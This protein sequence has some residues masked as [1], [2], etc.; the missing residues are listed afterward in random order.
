MRITRLSAIAVALTA[1]AM[2]AGTSAASAAT[3]TPVVTSKGMLTAAV[4]DTS[5][6]GP[7]DATGC[8]IGAYYDSGGTGKSVSSADISGAKQYGVFVDGIT[9]NVSVD[10]TDSSV[11]NT[12]DVPFDGNQYGI[13][14]YYYGY[15]TMGTVSGTVSGNSVYAYQKGGIVVNGGKASADV[16]DNTVTGLGP[17]P[18][19]AQNGIQ[20][21]FTATGVASGNQISENYYTGC[22]HQDAAKT[23][24]IPYVSAG[25]LLYDINPSQISRFNNKY[26]DD[27]RN[28]LVVTDAELNAHSS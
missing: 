27:Q 1:A 23:G 16:T 25:L 7:V 9:G 26:R 10:V 13:D 3:C 20:F 22:S 21:G 14:I 15:N 5:V 12:G 2:V 28:E 6:T 24:C 4:Y 8:D 11:H 18:Y 19:I 17:V